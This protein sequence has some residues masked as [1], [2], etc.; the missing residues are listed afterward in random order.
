MSPSP[1]FTIPFLLI[2]AIFQSTAAPRL[3]VS[4]VRPDLM[5]LSVVSWTLLAAFRA[6]ELQYAGE[7]PS[8]LRG[9]NDGVV[10]GFV[11]GVFLDLLSSAPLGASALALMTTALVVGVI[12]V[13]VSG[14]VPILVVLMAALGTL[15][16]HLIFL[17]LMA[18]IGRPVL[19]GQDLTGVILP[20]VAF[21]LVL[22]PAVYVLLGLLDRQTSRER[23]R[24]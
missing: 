12:G 1:Y 20:S 19:L 16:Y 5:L 24:W 6:R 11:G 8:L 22:I 18:L 10:W 17:T 2:V 7:P 15:I 4:G 3:A 23:L 13:G 9:I 14:A 21:N